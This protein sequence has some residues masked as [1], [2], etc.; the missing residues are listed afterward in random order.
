MTGA[1]RSERLPVVLAPRAVLVTATTA[2][3]LTLLFSGLILPGLL[4]LLPALPAAV[5]LF[6]LIGLSTSAR[7]LAGVVGAR[8][9]RRVRGTVRRGDALPSVIVGGGLAWGLALAL[10]LGTGPL[11]GPGTMVADLVRWMA[12][13]ALGALCV[14]PGA[15]SDD[16]SGYY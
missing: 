14:P 13:C 11:A 15:V 3:I 10:S 16:D 6:V 5:Q 12:E 9:V 2:F 8:R 7:V 4:D 1:V